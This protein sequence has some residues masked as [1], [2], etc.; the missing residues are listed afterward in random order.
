M[1]R[2]DFI[3]GIAGSTTA[4]PLTARAQ[5]TAKTPRVGFL[6]KM[7]VTYHLHSQAEIP[8]SEVDDHSII[9]LAGNQQ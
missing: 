4:W 9:S 7:L 5:P 6:G 3:S 2:R 1:R 8:P